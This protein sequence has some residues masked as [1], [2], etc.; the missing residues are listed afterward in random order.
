MNS[1][2]AVY[3]SFNT[4]D[5]SLN[6]RLDKLFYRCD[7]RHKFRYGKVRNGIATKTKLSFRVQ[8]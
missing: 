1:C 3:K 4:L 5:P 6:K 2:P 8:L 7:M